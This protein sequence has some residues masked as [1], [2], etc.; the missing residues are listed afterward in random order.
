M[1]HP[2]ISFDYIYQIPILSAASLHLGQSTTVKTISVLLDPQEIPPSLTTT[3]VVHS[4]IICPNPSSGLIDLFSHVSFCSFIHSVL[5]F[6]SFGPWASHL[7]SLYP[8]F[9]SANAIMVAILQLLELS[10]LLY[11]QCLEQCLA[12]TKHHISIRYYHC[13]Y[14]FILLLCN[15]LAKH[16]AMLATPRYAFKEHAV[17]Q[18]SSLV[19]YYHY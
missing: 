11:E 8:S 2:L 15:R 5:S 13:Y 9:S 4:T 16:C 7:T 6:Y 1:F 3:H 10:E 12:H 14:S 18:N 19:K 17:A